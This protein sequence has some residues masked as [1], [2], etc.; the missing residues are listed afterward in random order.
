MS[1]VTDR[2]SSRETRLPI[3]RVAGLAAVVGAWI[4][5]SG[6]FLTGFGWIVTNNVLVGAVIATLA[7]YTAA[8]PTGGR[9]PSLAGP[10][11]IA[12]LGVWTVAAPFFFGIE[13]GVLF[14]S[15]IVAG[16]LVAV[17]A[18]GS[19]YGVV[20]GTGTSASPAGRS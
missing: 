8:R 19:L 10:L 2:Q 14:W 3:P 9:L 15:N 16:A 13:T 20:T 18:V 6:V 11:V 12:I 7:A 4:F 1:T 17:L 5:W